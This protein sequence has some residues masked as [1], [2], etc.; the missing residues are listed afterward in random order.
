MGTEV[1]PSNFTASRDDQQ[2]MCLV[3]ITNLCLTKE[4][5]CCPGYGCVPFKGYHGNN[6]HP[7]LSD[8]QPTASVIAKDGW[9]VGGT[10]EGETHSV[11]TNSG[12]VNKGLSHDS[13]VRKMAAVIKSGE[14]PLQ[15]CVP[16]VAT[17]VLTWQ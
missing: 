9:P 11:Q 7:P 2:M 17:T 8:V 5:H 4:P 13:V 3:P 6:V 12:N 14:S 1:L 16:C 15:R 10:V